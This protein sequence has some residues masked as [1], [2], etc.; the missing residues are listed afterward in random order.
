MQK[1]VGD[2]FIEKLSEDLK[3]KS[4]RTS[5]PLYLSLFVA[6]KKLSADQ[7]IKIPCEDRKRS[8]NIVTSLGV[9]V[10][11]NKED[12]RLRTFY[13]DGESTLVI[14]KGSLK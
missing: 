6:L 13:N 10:R 8:T 2:F 3:F 4:G 11:K 12:F 9:K 5:N 1:Q 14:W 7:C